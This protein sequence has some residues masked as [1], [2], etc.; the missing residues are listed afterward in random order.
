[1]KT[2]NAIHYK[3]A[4]KEVQNEINRLRRFD[5][6]NKINEYKTTVGCP[7]GEK[8]AC[9]LDFHHVNQDKESSIAQLTSEQASWER[10]ELEIKKCI[11]VCSNCH[12]KIH[13]KKY[14]GWFIGA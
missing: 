13:A 3:N 10:I 8:E 11:V 9:C 7:C 1:M 5:L 14:P 12:R 6:K 2:L 4:Y